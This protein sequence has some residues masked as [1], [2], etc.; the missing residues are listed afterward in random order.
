MLNPGVYSPELL[1]KR[2]KRWG[3]ALISS[4][5]IY[6][7]V[8]SLPPNNWIKQ[9]LRTWFK[10]IHKQKAPPHLSMISCMFFFVFCFFFPKEYK[11]KG[12]SP[13]KIMFRGLE[14]EEK[15]VAEGNWE[16]MMLVVLSQE[17]QGSKTEWLRGKIIPFPC[18]VCPLGYNTHTCF[19]TNTHLALHSPSLYQTFLCFAVICFTWFSVL[20]VSFIPSFYMLGKWK[21]RW[22]PVIELFLI[23]AVNNDPTKVSWILQMAVTE[24][25]H[26][27]VESHW[28]TAQS[29]TC[30]NHIFLP[31][32]P[33]HTSSEQLWTGTASYE[34]RLSK[35]LWV[36]CIWVRKCDKCVSG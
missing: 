31:F 14:D 23:H 1:G 33:K 5:G 24:S 36:N 11:P 16:K 8:W 22:N 26:G 9:W 32:K 18:T 29:H 2:L 15:A 21:Q 35:N 10:A 30:S 28:D 19:I 7:S 3:S 25:L 27:N 13:N 34:T 12:L 4:V 6:L 17:K 20:S